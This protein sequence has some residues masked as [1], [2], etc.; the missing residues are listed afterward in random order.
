[1]GWRRLEAAVCHKEEVWLS[2]EKSFP[3]QQ[4]GELGFQPV[5]RTWPSQSLPMG[6]HGPK[7]V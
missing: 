4:W 7:Q 2:H 3:E 5:S 6:L 1:M